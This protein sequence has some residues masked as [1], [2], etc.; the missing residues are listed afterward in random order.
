[1]IRAS[2]GRSWLLIRTGTATG[3]IVYQGVLPQGETLRFSLRHRDL[4]LR[5]GRPQDLDVLLSGRL[6]T[7]LPAQA[8][9]LLLTRSGAKA[10]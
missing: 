6:V 2:R 3:P 9:N 10:A 5:M 7:G 8:A 1:M 4:W